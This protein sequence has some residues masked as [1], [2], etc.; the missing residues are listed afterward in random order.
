MLG[1]KLYDQL[2]ERRIQYQVIQHFIITQPAST[3]VIFT[4]KSFSISLWFFLLA[5]FSSLQA[6][7]HKA[8]NIVNLLFIIV[9]VNLG[10]SGAFGFVDTLVI[11]EN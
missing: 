11:K 10:L 8:V 4:F 1:K 3:H 7:L 9:S 6:F 2:D 5:S